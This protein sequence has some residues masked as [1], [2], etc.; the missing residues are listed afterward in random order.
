MPGGAPGTAGERRCP[1]TASVGPESSKKQTTCD[2]LLPAKTGAAI[3]TRNSGEQNDPSLNAYYLRARYY[4]NASGR[5]LTGD[6]FEG[7]STSPI[8]LH[9]YLYGANDPVNTLDRSG[10]LTIYDQVAAVTILTVLADVAITSTAVYRFATVGEGHFSGF[11]ASLRANT[12]IYPRSGWV[13]RQAS[14]SP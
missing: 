5:F 10:L 2:E 12:T 4:N 11:L 13:W 8:S 14:I 1:E 6:S 7:Q 9:R 3:E